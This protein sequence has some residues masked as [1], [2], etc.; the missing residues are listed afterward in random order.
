MPTLIDGYNLLHALGLL[1]GRRG[2]HALE[3]A[4][5]S[6]LQRLRSSG[7]SGVTV[8][9]DAAGAP[10]GAPREVSHGDIRFVFARETADDLIEELVR[11]A[12]A[13]RSLV[14]VS[15][16][17]RLRKAAQRRGCA[18]LG[19]VD[20]CERLTAPPPAAPAPDPA[21]KPEVSPGE[22]ERWMGVFGEDDDPFWREGF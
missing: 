8:V 16:D 14:V 2:P 3:S 21:G 22:T 18:V 6:L 15:D 4:R 10:P 12:S 7:A 5:A 19:C 11:R 20:Y 13:P 1:A 17:I 9:F